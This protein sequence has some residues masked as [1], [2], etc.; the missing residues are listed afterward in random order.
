[1]P[2]R[3]A[4]TESV[5]RVILWGSLSYSVISNKFN[6]AGK[7]PVNNLILQVN[8]SHLYYNIIN[9]IL[10]FYYIKLPDKNNG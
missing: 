8:K 6:E 10:R 4:A 7:M 5:P 3:C 2:T 1:M 9:V